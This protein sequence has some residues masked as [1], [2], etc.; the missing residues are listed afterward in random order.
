[1]VSGNGTTLQAI[2]D[3]IKSKELDVEIKIVISNTKDAYALTRANE[4]GI[5]N[6]LLNDYKD[7]N[8]LYDI[9]K[10]SNVELIVLAGYLKLIPLKVIR[11]FTIINTHPALLPKYGGKGMYGMNV[12]RAVV[13]NKEKETGATLHFVNGEYDKGKIISQTKVKVY[14]KDTPEDV[15]ARVQKAEKIQLIRVLKDF[16]NGKIEI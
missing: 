4:A 6:C 12:H 9:L 14:K 1:M 8:E 10:S 15:S 7:E 13:E 2:I 3:A 11:D 5:K 16:S